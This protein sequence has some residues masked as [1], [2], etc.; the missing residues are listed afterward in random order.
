[1]S[2]M[3]FKK[4]LK[5]IWL[6]AATILSV[7][8]VAA[9]NGGLID[10]LAWVVPSILAMTFPICIIANCIAGIVNLFVSRKSAIVQLSAVLLSVNGLA[11]FCPVNY[12]KPSAAS[13]A[14]ENLLRCMTYNTFGFQD[15]EK[16]YPDSTNRT[17]SQI[18]ASDADII[19]LQES[20]LINPDRTSCITEAQ[21]DTLNR[22]YP[23]KVN[24]V[25]SFFILSKHPLKPID[26]PLPEALDA[27]FEMAETE[28]C[29]IK[30]LIVN[31]H[32][33]S[34]GLTDSDKQNYLNIT[35]G[36]DD[37]NWKSDSKTLYHKL[38][39]AFRERAEQAEFIAAKLDSLAYD[40]VLLCG[41]FNDIADCY[42]MR[43]ICRHQ[44]KSAYTTAGS[45][46]MITYH[47][48]RFY[49]HID[50]ILYQGALK[51]LSIERG[52]IPSSDHYPLYC[53]FLIDR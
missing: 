11:A 43:R 16:V 49:F 10:P 5:I 33:K 18:I 30:L 45:G 47:D 34:I 1:M 40:N 44:M 19:T 9:A 36:H 28:Y 7:I 23:Y 39:D 29:G 53:T 32:L 52:R 17:I 24:E 51:P 15:A 35:S 26:I 22:I 31:V 3:K 6:T 2:D 48:N 42:A 50:H 14:P 12:P 37:E 21:L 27:P 38:A 41:D 4:C 13:I 8:T 46:P 25:E 20:Y